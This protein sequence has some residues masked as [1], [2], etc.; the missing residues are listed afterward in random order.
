MA[1]ARLH[2]IILAAVRSIHLQPPARGIKSRHHFLVGRRIV[3]EWWTTWKTA[4]ATE[5][6]A[7]V[8]KTGNAL[9]ASADEA[10]L[11]E[12]FIECLRQALIDASLFD[13]QAILSQKVPT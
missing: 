5:K 3:I 8:A 10:Y 9:L 2:G 13:M 12:L 11:A 6:L 1:F 7:S 4:L